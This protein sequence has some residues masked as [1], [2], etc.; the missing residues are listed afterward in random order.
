MKLKEF[1]FHSAL[2]LPVYKFSI[3][4]IKLKYSAF[5]LFDLLLF[6]FKSKLGNNDA[7]MYIY[8]FK[9]KNYKETLRL[10]QWQ[11]IFTLLH[12]HICKL[13]FIQQTLLEMKKN[14]FNF[15]DAC[16]LAIGCK[17]YFDLF[18]KKSKHGFHVLTSFLFYIALS[19]KWSIDREKC[20]VSTPST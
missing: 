6:H 7:F 16:P 8:T 19:N 12:L 2:F 14:I 15:S 1:E 4:D 9:K 3:L 11:C 20:K 18:S 10:Q 13:S 5:M 17:S